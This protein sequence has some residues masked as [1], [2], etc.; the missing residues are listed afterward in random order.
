MLPGEVL[1]VMTYNPSKS[2]TDTTPN[3]DKA[4]VAIEPS[5]I[6]N[7]LS[8]PVTDPNTDDSPY[9]IGDFNTAS[10]DD[11]GFC[12]AP[13]L[14]VARLRLPA[15]TADATMCPPLAAAPAVD[16]QYAFSNVRSYA[17]AAAMGTQLSA[18]LTYTTT[19][20]TGATC[21]AKYHVRAVY[22]AVSCGAPAPTTGDDGGAAE[23]GDDSSSPAPDAGDDGSSAPVSEAGDDSSSASMA[24]ATVDDAGGDD[25]GCDAGAAAAPSGPMIPSIALCNPYPDYAAGM[26]IGSGLDPDYAIACDPNLLLCVL[27]KEP[28]SLR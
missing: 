21:V 28:P 7:L 15:V 22:P 23:A 1:N 6:T 25:G 24:D 17:T 2:A 10:P 26:P 13:T 14:T 20:P 18:D 16:V 19:D 11:S 9:G 12:V 5:G 27:S 4:S 3:W 8:E